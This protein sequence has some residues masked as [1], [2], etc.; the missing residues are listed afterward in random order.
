MSDYGRIYLTQMLLVKIYGKIFTD[1]VREMN[2]IEIYCE[3]FP[4]EWGNWSFGYKQL[5]TRL[6]SVITYSPHEISMGIAYLKQWRNPTRLPRECVPSYKPAK[7][8]ATSSGNENWKMWQT[9][10]QICAATTCYAQ[11]LKD[12]LIDYLKYDQEQDET[13]ACKKLIRN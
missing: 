4:N 8:V 12:E 3:W 5:C 2:D 10:L 11:T 13:A 6:L 9:P 1:V 7:S